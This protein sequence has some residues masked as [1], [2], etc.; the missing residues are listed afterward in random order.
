[1]RILVTGAC[2]F[3]G[4]HV[5]NEL[6]GAGH[7]PLA[8]DVIQP[9]GSPIPTDVHVGDLRNVSVLKKMVSDLAPDACVHLAGIAFVPM[10]WIDPELVFSVNLL[11]TINLL[12]AFRVGAP[13]ARLLIVSSAEV[14]G[15]DPDLHVLTENAPL[16]P[17]NLYAVSKMAADLSSLLYASRYGMQVM[18]ARPG[19]HIGPGQS[20]HF[21]TAAFAEQLVKIAKHQTEPMLK[22]GNLE[23]E[24]DFT[25]VRDVA[26]AYRLIVESGRAGEAY[27]ISSEKWVKISAIL[28]ELCRLTGV[29][30]E[31]IV[32]P[33]RYRSFEAHP[34]MDSSK[35]RKEVGWAPRI[36][37]STTLKDVLA[38][39]ERRI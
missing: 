5:V 34:Q 9:I 2:G 8:M 33:Q 6:M 15:C 32:D 26:R 7:A 38:D 10:G 16:R 17:I 20:P 31:L 14:Y 39:I 12:E 29:R 28:D 25:D 35:I 1:V 4:R 23:C 19:N 13:R 30:P 3:V 18:T 11:G 22:V 36:D 27:N 21:V 37:L 24:R